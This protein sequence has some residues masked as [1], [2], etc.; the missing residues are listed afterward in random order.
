[1]FVIVQAVTALELRR[2]DERSGRGA[3]DPASV[4]KPGDYVVPYPDA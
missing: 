3:K 1:V 4:P 2:L